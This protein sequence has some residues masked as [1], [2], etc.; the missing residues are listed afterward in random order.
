MK[1]EKF[2]EFVVCEKCGYNNHPRNVQIYGSCLRCRH[3]LDKKVKFEYDMFNKLKM[4]RG[5]KSGKWI[6]DKDN[7]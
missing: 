5:K 6:A 4:W 3:V 7:K 2:P 1:K